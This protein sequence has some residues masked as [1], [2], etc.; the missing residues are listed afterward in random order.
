VWQEGITLRQA[1]ARKG[2]YYDNLKRWR[3]RKRQ[4]DR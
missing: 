2:V 1:A 4:L 3:A